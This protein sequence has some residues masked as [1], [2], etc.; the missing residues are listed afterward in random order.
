MNLSVYFSE[1]VS[2]TLAGTSNQLFFDC[3]GERTGYAF[4]RIFKEG[5]FDYSFFYTNT[6][7][8]TF[9]KGEISRAGD[10]CGSY[11]IS[12]L[13]VA[14]IKNKEAALSGR[15]DFLPLT[16]DGERTRTVLPGEAFVSDPVSLTVDRDDYLCLR[17]T[18]SGGRL[19][20]HVENLIP[21]YVDE[22]KGAVSS[23]YLPLPSMVG[24]RRPVRRQV[25]FWGD[26][27]TQGIGTP[28]DSY[29]GYV[30]VAAREL[31]SEYSFWNLGIGYGRAEDAATDGAWAAKVR[32]CDT[33]VVCFGVN[34]ILH[35]GDFERAKTAISQIAGILRD[36]TVIFQLIPPFDY[37]REKGEIY[38]AL[39]EHIRTHVAPRVTAVFDETP[40]LAEKENPLAAIY[41]GHPNPQGCHIWGERLA[42]FLSPFL[43][44]QR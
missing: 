26:S 16:F 36:K 31:G 37:N 28:E 20:C 2:N 12:A 41:G 3:P 35:V 15:A 33:A 22:G 14:V 27:I 34:D 9:G 6:V 4:Y 43:K 32:Q 10:L 5:R 1:Y 11:E 38:Q 8:S 24:V 23:K 19:P 40:F 7:D 13:S 21:T 44:E 30:P 29:L 25:A 39:N 18:F 17:M 42:A